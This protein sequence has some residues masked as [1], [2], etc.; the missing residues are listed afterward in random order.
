MS[1]YLVTNN[2]RNYSSK[3]L[4]AA[5]TKNYVPQIVYFFYGSHVPVTN[6]NSVPEISEDYKNVNIDS[7][8]NMIAG[9]AV[10]VNDVS[11]VIRNIPLQVFR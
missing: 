10:S 7:Y 5:L 6:T 8:R 2:Y 1:T 3:A 11:L 4:I 9:K